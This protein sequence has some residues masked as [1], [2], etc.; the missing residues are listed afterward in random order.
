MIYIQHRVNS[1]EDLMLTDSKYGVEID[2]RNHGQE[3]IVVHDPF[4]DQE[5]NFENWLKYFKHNFLIINVKEEGLEPKI[6]DLLD[7]ILIEFHLLSTQ[8]VESTDLV[9]VESM[10]SLFAHELCGG[11]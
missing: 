2:I 1:I 7:F 5:I 4:L 10:P 6:F 8:W 3:L 9:S 11:L